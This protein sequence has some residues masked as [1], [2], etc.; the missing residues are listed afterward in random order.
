MSADARTERPFYR[1]AEEAA[2]LVADLQRPGAVELFIQA[3]RERRARV[4]NP[5]TALSNQPPLTP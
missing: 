4:A 1:T 3:I 2:R 5:Q